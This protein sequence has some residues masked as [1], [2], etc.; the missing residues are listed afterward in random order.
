M[1]LRHSQM[2]IAQNPR[3]AVYL[4][5]TLKQD[6]AYIEEILKIIQSANAYCDDSGEGLAV[7]LG[8]SHARWS[9]WCESGSY[10]MPTAFGSAALLGQ[11]TPPFALSSFDL[12]FQIKGPEIDP[13]CALADKITKEIQASATDISRTDAQ[14]RHSGKVIGGRFFDGLINPVAPEDVSARVLIGDEDPSH[15]GGSFA[16]TQRFKHNW[17]RIN[18]M[19]KVAKEDMIG[20]REDDGILP[21]DDDRS[22]IKCVRQLD[23]EDRVNFRIMR[24]AVPFGSVKGFAGLEEGVFFV[25]FAKETPAFDKVIGGMIGDHNGFIRDKLMNVTHANEGNY[26]YIPN[27]VELGLEEKER[28]PNIALPPYFDRRS[29]NGYM[30]YNAKDY[31]HKVR[32][33]KLVEDAPISERILKLLNLNFSRWHDAWYKDVQT[34]PLGHLRDHVSKQDQWVLTASPALRK[35]KATQLALSEVLIS[36]DYS[37]KANT[38]FIIPSEIIVGNMPNLS[39]GIGSQVMEYLDQDEKITGFFGMLNEYSATG[40]N[41]PDYSLALHLGIGGL[42]EKFDTALKGAKDQDAKDFYQSVI[43]A[44]DGL[45]KFIGAYSDLAVKTRDK[46]AETQVEERENLS[47][48]AKR[49]AHLSTEPARDFLDAA[50]LIYI[51]NCALHQTGEP[52]S[53]GRLD[54]WLGEFYAQDIKSG[55]LTEEQA[56]EIIDAFWIK[57]DETVLFNR[58]QLKDY[59]TYGTGAVF[60]SAGNFPQGA[61]INQWVQQLTVGGYAGND[62]KTPQDA[63]NGVTKLC[64]RS[65]RRLPFNAPCLSLRV[66]KDMD[67]DLLKEA[68]KA[69]LSGGAHPIF[70][71]DDKLVPALKDAGNLALADA[72]SYSCDGCYEPIIPGKTEWAFSYVPLLPFVGYAMNQGTAIAGAGPI[73]LRGLKQSWNSPSPEEIKDFDHFLEIFFTHWRWAMNGFYNTL[74]HGYG[75]LWPICPSPLFSS[76]VHDC[77]DRGRDMTNGGAQYHIIAPMMCGITNAIDSLFAVKKLV[78]DKDT[79]LTTLPEL[80]SCLMCDWGHDMIEPLYNYQAGPD[81]AEIA[82]ERFKFLRKASFD[83]PKFGQGTSEEVVE[84]AQ[85]VVGTCVD[86]I[87]DSFKSPVKEVAQAY[88]ALKAKYG[89]KDAPFFFSVTPGVGTFEDNVGLGL[90]M[91]ASPD[92][93]RA[94]QPICDDFCPIPTPSDLPATGDFRPVSAL[95]QWNIEPI[96]HGI[97]NAAPIDLNIEEDFPE[98]ALFDLL[99]DFAD[100][101]TG[102]N[103]ITISCANIDT[104]Q[105]AYTYP[106]AYDLVRTRMGG[107]TEF[108]VAM[109]PEH[110]NYIMRRPFFRPD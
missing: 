73:H 106:E 48:I 101:K 3:C 34:P 49:M 15:K 44:L 108:F 92:G 72:R 109:F 5:V 32:D 84:L 82:S 26:W 24:Q 95:H 4:S 28:D 22:H 21:M 93:R 89:T 46:L 60:Y 41:A 110:K 102:S 78:Y 47:A 42:I 27:A 17:A 30:F 8:F 37:K 56:Q 77:L 9:M 70:L 83:L 63:S 88:D 40:H 36:K 19:S 31:L 107:W 7:I 90:G 69:V 76:M 51:I 23:T 96:N 75:A 33:S 80:L 43:W 68:A 87:H 59:L 71:N 18:D 2:G 14:K 54:Q 97:A 55:A 25:G 94:T 86:I 104:M 79:A 38:Y 6:K 29:D 53:I 52:M 85:K 99:R 39:L 65:A 13:C 67:D 98:D 1:S 103:M 66:H 74:M 45:S 91:G 57:M 64:L 12:W 16:I 61:A 35:G 100:G 62:A 58:K 10:T 50:Q 81:R 105:Q 11:H 20:R